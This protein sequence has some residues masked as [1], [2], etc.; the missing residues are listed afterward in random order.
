MPPINLRVL[1]QRLTGEPAPLGS[2]GPERAES[3][4]PEQGIGYSQLNEVLLLLGYD[5][6]AQPFFQYLLNGSIDYELG[7]AFTE[8]EQISVGID[9]FRTHAMLHFGNIKY[10]FKNWSP[11]E[12]EELAEELSIFEPIDEAEYSSRHDAVLPVQPIDGK[13]TYYLGYIIEKELKSRLEEKPEDAQAKQEEERRTSL[14]ARGIQ[15]QQAYLASDH[16]DVYVATSMRER[17]E[18]SFVHDTV[19]RIFSDERLKALKLRWFDP[20]QA[21]CI[22]RIDKGLAEALMLKRAGCTLYLAQETDTLGKDSELAS[23]LAQGKVV[24]AY[25][26]Q[27]AEGEEAQYTKTLLETAAELYPGRNAK[28]LLTRQLQVYAPRI[29]WENADIRRWI[30]DPESCSEEDMRE[31]LGRTVRQFYNKRADTLKSTHPLGIQVHLETGVANG[32][33]VART[34]PECVELIDRV[35]MHQLE[36]EIDEQEI[37]GSTYLLLLEK[38]TGS[39]FRVVTGDRFL[40]HTF[41]NFYPRS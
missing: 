21:Y 2:D 15:N 39:V 36:F 38:I 19:A 6:I 13:E 31:L 23:T 14:V 24:I 27:V 40:T 4:L 29:A 7:N 9:R 33:I 30:D 12:H 37:G 11:L 32:V 5:R 41:W 18:Y 26:P 28:E 8:L 34:I 35:L 3:L 20:T 22:D 17:H 1:L 10:A 16:M 25:V